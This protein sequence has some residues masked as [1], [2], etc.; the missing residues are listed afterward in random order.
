MFQVKIPKTTRKVS[1][2]KSVKKRIVHDY[3]MTNISSLSPNGNWRNLMFEGE[4]KN[5]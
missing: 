3:K 5:L 4:K 1:E 2:E